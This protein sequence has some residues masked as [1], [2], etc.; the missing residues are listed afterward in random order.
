LAIG[1]IANTEEKNGWELLADGQASQALDAFS[2]QSRKHPKFAGPII[3]YA[4]SVA[5]AGD[6]YFGV[7]EMRR[8]SRTNISSMQAFELPLGLRPTVEKLIEDFKAEQKKNTRKDDVSFMLAALHY[9]M[10]NPESAKG[11]IDLAIREGDDSQSTRNLK[12]SLDRQT[13]KSQSNRG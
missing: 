3:G 11:A 8:A 9:L 5:S 12:R 7:W 13:T 6:L 10:Q 4:L 1:Q 2:Q